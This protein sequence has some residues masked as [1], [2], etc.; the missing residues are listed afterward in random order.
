MRRCTRTLLTVIAAALAAVTAHQSAQ[1]GCGCDKPPPPVASVR[2]SVAYPGAPITFFAKFVEGG[3]YV[4]TFTS[5]MTGASQ[6]VAGV[7]VRRRDLADRGPKLQVEVPM[8]TLPLGPVSIVV[9]SADDGTTLLSIPDT[10]FTAAAAPLPVPNQL[11]AWELPGAQGAVSRDGVVYIALD[12]HDM[13]DPMVVTAQALGYPLR[14]TENDVVFYNRQGFLM[15]RLVASAKNGTQPVPGMF[16]V[17]AK[18]G[19]TDSDELHYSRHEFVT[20][21]LQ[22]E[23]RQPHQVDPTDGNWHIDGSP[24]VDHDH[25]ILAIFGRLN[26]GSKPAPGATPVFDLKLSTY[27]LFHS[28]VLGAQYA[29]VGSSSIV[30]SY[31]SDTMTRGSDAAVTSLVAA[32]VK[33]QGLVMGD[34]IAPFVSIEGQGKLTGSA[35]APTSVGS[36][37]AIKIPSGIPSLGDIDVRTGVVTIK[38]PGSFVVRKLKIAS[39][40]RVFV[41]NAAGPVTLYTTDE[42]TIADKAVVDLADPRPERFAIY[43]TSD[44]PVQIQGTSRVAGALYAPNAPVTIA[45]DADVSG[46]VVGKT[47]VTKDRARVHYDS[48]LRGRDPV[49]TCMQ[50]TLFAPIPGKPFDAKIQCVNGQTTPVAFAATDIDTPFGTCTI[51]GG[52]PKIVKPLSSASF[53]V[54]VQCDTIAVPFTLTIEGIS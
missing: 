8:P 50:A 51:V 47:V 32:K 16:I 3:S 13:Q 43:A 30:D 44:K 39:G 19:A 7:A 24:H 38:G 41:D 14:F 36:I 12:L 46:A 42:V 31:D 2:P 17:P 49:T 40:A 15:Q 21:F 52:A 22:H 33:D 37:M 35:W 34:V 20:Y 48:T 53:T 25:L 4:A 27:S 28:G 1:A 45:G 29:E 26:D 10:D 11:G 6:A 5:S 18:N 54:K 23:E 9:A